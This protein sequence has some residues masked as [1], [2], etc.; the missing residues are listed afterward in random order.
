MRKRQNHPDR[1][2]FSE[3]I[4][5]ALAIEAEDAREAG[6]LGFMGRILVQA[7][8]PH[9]KREEIYFSRANGGYELAITAH[10]KHGLP[11]GAKPRLLLA[12]LATE[13]VRTRSRTIPLGHT[14]SEFMR[15]LGLSITGGKR[16][17][18]A[19]VKEQ[20]WR[21]FTATIHTTYR[22]P[23]RIRHEVLQ[24]V[25]AIDWW[26]IPMNPH[27]PTWRSTVELSEKFYR[28]LINSPVPVDMRA[29]ELFKGSSMALDIY[30]WLT[31]RMST[32]K[33]PTL[34][35]WSVLRAQFGADYARTR[36]FKG[37]FLRELKRVVVIYPA[38]VEEITSGL[39]LKPSPSHV[40]A[41]RRL[42]VDKP[43]TK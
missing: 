43:V 7:T 34:I 12:W 28:E 11:Y 5:E 24:I 36:D 23:D 10:P 25:E 19:P 29:L 18:I 38:L 27:E 20:M 39:L 15:N 32:L 17:T 9:R 31:Y 40:R 30:M 26:W 6:M 8:L 14:L 41:P 42:G 37:K 13:A 33:E 3:L 35:R 1:S 21:L 4:A 22:E 16:G 2:S